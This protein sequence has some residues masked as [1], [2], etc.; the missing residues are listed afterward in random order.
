MVARRLPFLSS[1][2]VPAAPARCA[3]SATGNADPSRYGPRTLAMAV[4]LTDHLWSVKE[5]LAFPV[6]Q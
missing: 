5:L 4:S 1:A 6:G 3:A 2:L